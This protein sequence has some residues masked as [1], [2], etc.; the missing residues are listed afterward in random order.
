MRTTVVDTGPSA[1]PSSSL[2]LALPGSLGSADS[3]SRFS[4]E[5]CYL[6]RPS[7]GPSKC[8]P[9][10]SSRHAKLGDSMMSDPSAGGV[11]LVL[12]VSFRRGAHLD[13]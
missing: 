3:S 12:N 2:V 8:T 4:L 10:Y 5:H 6:E 9:V 1:S 11:T 7:S 13:L